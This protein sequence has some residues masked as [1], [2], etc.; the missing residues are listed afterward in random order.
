MSSPRCSPNAALVAGAALSAVLCGCIGPDFP[1]AEQSLCTVAG[2][3]CRPECAA[4]LIPGVTTARATLTYHLGP[5]SCAL[6][7]VDDAHRQAGKLCRARGL[8]LAV[9]ASPVTGE[10]PVAPLPPAET[11]TFQCERQG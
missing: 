4:T 8:G 5:A 10:P 11:V 3:G 2:I 7:D 1:T 9:A 6:V